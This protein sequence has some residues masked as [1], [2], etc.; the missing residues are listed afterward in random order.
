MANP[1][2]SVLKV[3]K[4]SFD[5][6]I[7]SR[8]VPFVSPFNTTFLGLLSIFGFIWKMPAADAAGY[9]FILFFKMM[10]NPEKISRIVCS[11]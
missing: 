9:F 5:I 3:T 1:S 6:Y 2:I 4:L 10:Q 8:F 11:S 7:M